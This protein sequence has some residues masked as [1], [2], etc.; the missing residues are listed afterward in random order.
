MRLLQLQEGT[1]SLVEF[2]GSNI[3]RYAILSHT[4]G[5]EDEEVNFQD[6]TLLTN[7]G[8]VGYRKLYFCG[9]QA[10]K[11]GLDYFWV[12]TCCID[13]TNLPELSEAINS[14]F[15]WYQKAE[16]CYVYLSDVACGEDSEGMQRWKPAFRKSRW[17]TRGW[18]L[19]ELIA[20]RT[21]E[22]YS[23]DGSYLGNK[24]TLE[25]T[26]HEITDIPIRALQDEPFRFSLKDRESW[27]GTRETTIEEDSA[28]CLLGIFDIHLPLIY[29]EGRDH[30]MRRLRK[31]I[32]DHHVINL[33]IATGASFNSHMEEHKAKFLPNTRTDLLHCIKEWVDD[34]DSPSMF[35]L[36]GIAGTG[37]STVART[38]ATYFADHNRL[39]ASFF[40]KKGEGERGTT[41]RFFSTIAADLAACEPGMV[42]SIKAAQEEDPSMCQKTLRDQF[43]KLILHPL[44]EIPQV[45][46]QHLPLVIVIDALDECEQDDDIRTILQLL[47]QTHTIQ[48]VSLRVLVTSRPDLPIR[49][50]FKQMP[51]G[52]YQNV[53]LHEIPQACIAHDILVFLEYQLGAMRQSHFLS[54]EWPGADQI[55]A[56]V[57]L[58]VPLFIYAAT[59]CRY[60]GTK[61]G[62]PEDYLNKVLAYRKPTFSQLDRT[63]LPILDQLLAEQEDD[64]KATWLTTFKELVGCI[65]LLESPLSVTSLARLLQVPSNKIMRRLDPLHSVLSIPDDE[66]GPVRI[67][68]LSFREFLIDSRGSTHHPF[69][70]DRRRTD[71]KLLSQ[72]MGLMSGLNGFRQNICDLPSP[73][74]LCSDVDD[75]LVA[76]SLS[77][78]L[79]Y[80]CRYW[81]HHLEQSG[82]HIDDGDV[83]HEFLRVH[84]LHWIE[85][86]SLLDE[87]DQCVPLINKLQ[88]LTKVWCSPS[89]HC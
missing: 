56:L 59:V 36:S 50:G 64:D 42:S 77:P 58:A 87:I 6:V 47:S 39:G 54:P 79:Q 24:E 28:Y 15:R 63:Y 73:G 75:E 12:D 65:V 66:R 41:A 9:E 4:W 35:W 51:D 81:I 23:S 84:L 52:T 2:R 44:L 61:G 20:P 70:V 76:I 57:D 37:K 33:P 46:S 30:A 21:V 34:R 10:K 17:F 72:C 88:T 49:I 13:K 62:D 40:F 11:D 67:L 8:K 89:H 38:V 85:A 60:I 78:E 68:H 29:G 82:H 5:L 74:T 14:M 19:Q 25:Q 7:E 16:K 86:M 48:P 22:F 3:P 71:E 18:T 26:V 83:V 69:W 80:A 31:E 53:V 1:L 43:E 32:R 55:Q 27:L 45:Q